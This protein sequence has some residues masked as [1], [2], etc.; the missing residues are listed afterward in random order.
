VADVAAAEE[1]TGS[2]A[3]GWW[4]RAGLTC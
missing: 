4:R 3:S 2:G 1:G